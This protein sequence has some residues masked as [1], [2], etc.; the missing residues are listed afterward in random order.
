MTAEVKEVRR[1]HRKCV[2]ADL[3]E[4]SLARGWWKVGSGPGGE[5]E[6]VY[7]SLLGMLV[8]VVVVVMVVAVK[9]VKAKDV[10]V[11]LIMVMKVKVEIVVVAKLLN[12]SKD[13]DDITQQLTSISNP[14][15]PTLPFLS[16]PPSHPITS[17]VLLWQASYSSILIWKISLENLSI[18]YMKVIIV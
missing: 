8:P 14:P 2:E 16:R 11:E 9:V 7:G 1:G 18:H 5:G 15:A 3:L 13:L 17:L 12:T 10:A 4:P 6:V